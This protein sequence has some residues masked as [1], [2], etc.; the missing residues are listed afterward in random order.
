[1]TIGTRI[2]MKDRKPLHT[3]LPLE[4]PLV[5]FIDPMDACSLACSFCPTSDNSLMKGAGRPLRQMDFEL[6]KK[7]IDDLQ[8]FETKVKVLR[9]YAHGEPLLNKN[10][11]EMVEY[12]KK[13]GKVESV[14]T[15]TNGL[16]LNPELNLKLA[17]SGIDRIN[18]SVNGLNEEEYMAL[19]KRKVNF[20][21]FV[22]NIKNLYENKGNTYLFIKINGDTIS[23]ENE[24]KFLEIFEPIADSVGIERSFNCWNEFDAKGFNDPNGY[25]PSEDSV[26][27]YGQKNKEVITC[28]YVFYSMCINS[29]GSVSQC[30]LDWSLK[31][32]I[33]DIR[34]ESVREVWTNEKMSNVRKMMLE[35]KRKSHPICKGCNQLIGGQPENLDPHKEKLMK[36]YV[37]EN[38]ETP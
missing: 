22:S 1:M 7:V 17:K 36:T 35:G 19:T 38:K 29:S 31:L 6:Y 37:P 9:L 23:K 33:G 5:L 8:E 27:I 20:E 25:N 2:I 12:A 16:A 11:C 30:F 28:P 14:D 4:A 26:G 15:T 24:K 32:I 3:L 10:F 18:I 21:K 34:K 13:S